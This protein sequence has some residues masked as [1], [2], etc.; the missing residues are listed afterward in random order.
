MPLYQPIVATSRTTITGGGTVALGGFTLTVPATGTAALLGANNAFTGA[1]TFNQN[2]SLLTPAT[3]ITSNA[4]ELVLEQTGD[5]LGAT[6]MRLQNRSGSN[7]AIFQNATLDLV[8]FQFAGSTTTGTLR[9][10]ARGG[11][12]I[13]AENP[14]WWVV[15][16]NTNFIPRLTVSANVVNVN[17]GA[18][19]AWYAKSSTN[20]W[21]EWCRIERAAVVNT[22]ASRTGR[23]IL[24]AIDFNA[25]RE[26]MRGEANGTVALIGLYGGTAVAQP[27][28]ITAP[29][30]GATVDT[31]ARTAI[32]S[33][34]NAIGAAAG[35]IGITA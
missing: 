6:R 15:P 8:D 21:R 32:V 2:V 10:E 25:A 31:E 35:G 30:G 18:R 33:I 16:N 5:S 3:T 29:S 11:G 34:L 27:S 9:Y 26:F 28:A 13:I 7:G 4:T 12:N 17:N 22:D 14:E 23:M 20:A 1:N 24:S 19:L